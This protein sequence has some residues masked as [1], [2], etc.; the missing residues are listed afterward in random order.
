M[1][2]VN[3]SQRRACF[4][5]YTTDVKNGRV[6][7]WNCY[8]WN[9]E[10]DNKGREMKASKRKS[11]KRSAGKKY[12]KQGSKKV[13]HVKSGKKVCLS[14]RRSPARRIFNGPRGGQYVYSRGKKIY[15]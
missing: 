2:F 3:E 6:P 15:I 13:C 12:T 4:A 7:S 5:Q 10:K 14:S 8:K 11:V 9:D 1:P